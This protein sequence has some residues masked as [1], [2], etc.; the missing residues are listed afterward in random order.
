MWHAGVTRILNWFLHTMNSSFVKMI[1][2][3]F[4]SHCVCVCVFT[5]F[6]CKYDLQDSSVI[7]Q[8]NVKM[9]PAAKRKHTNKGSE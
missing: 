4:K 5:V 3:S 2:C 6:S 8:N 1:D 7:S 9:K